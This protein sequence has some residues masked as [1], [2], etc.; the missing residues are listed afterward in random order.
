M[1]MYKHVHCIVSTSNIQKS[2]VAYE[3]N[4]HSNVNTVQRYTHI[5]V[6]VHTC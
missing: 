3:T 5:H 1:Y 6:Y 4:Y 2:L